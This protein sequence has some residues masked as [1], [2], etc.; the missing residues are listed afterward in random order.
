MLDKGALT[1]RVGA[2]DYAAFCV[3]KVACAP[4]TRPDAP[5]DA[6]DA[7]RMGVR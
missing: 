6:P 1:V 2:A 7:L 3:R 4:P 5:S